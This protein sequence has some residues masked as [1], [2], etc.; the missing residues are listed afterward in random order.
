MSCNGTF[1]QLSAMASRHRP[2][3]LPAEEDFMGGNKQ[4]A[5][6]NKR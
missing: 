5:S 1:E 6:F 4:A 3:G 2:E